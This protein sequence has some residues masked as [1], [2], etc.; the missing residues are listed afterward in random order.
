MTQNKGNMYNN[1]IVAK[2]Q[3]R[4][5]CMKTTTGL[6]QAEPNVNDH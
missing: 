3:L 6:L 5:H 2:D 4:L 1:K